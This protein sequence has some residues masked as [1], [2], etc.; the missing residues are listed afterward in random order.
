[1]A[2]RTQLSENEELPQSDVAPGCAHPRHVYDLIGHEQA[3][4]R[5]AEAL[6]S[7]RMHHAWLLTGPA[8][9]GKATLAYRLIRTI[10][11]GQPETP[12]RLDVPI[13]DAVA[14]RVGSL[15]HGDFMLLRRPYDFKTKKIRTQIP[16]A[17][18][19][20]LQDFYSRK[21]AEGGWRVCLIDTADDMTTEAANGVLKTLEEPPEKALLILLSSE[22]GRLLP[23]IRSRCMHLPLREVPL[24]QIEAWLGDQGYPASLAKI[25]ASLSRGAPGKAHALAENEGSVL[26]PLQ[27]LMEAFPAGNSQL[28]HRI[29]DTLASPSNEAARALFW[30]ALSDI[31][32]AQAAYG[33]TGERG[34]SFPPLRLERSPS[35]WL[36]LWD[37]LADMKSAEA[38]LNMDKKT[39]MLGALGAMRAG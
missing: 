11:G 19:R 33:A 35:F 8:G 7:G 26:R 12:G 6:Q 14:H 28:E 36:N 1:M 13:D 34:A 15:G 2:R 16:V 9:V 22:P 31:V 24:P 10:L 32:Q 37:K 21:A 20:L 30:D 27:S 23:T 17:E 3:E 18:T 25:A 38:G 29:S 5:M 4:R 39:V